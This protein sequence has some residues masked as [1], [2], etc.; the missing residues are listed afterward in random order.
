MRHM[1]FL[2]ARGTAY[3]TPMSIKPIHVVGGGLAGS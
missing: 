3:K 1:G 2:S